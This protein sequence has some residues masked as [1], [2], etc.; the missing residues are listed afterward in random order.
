MRT[1]TSVATVMCSTPVMSS[2][3]GAWQTWP[4]KRDTLSDHGY[5]FPPE[6]I[7]YA[8]WLYHRAPQHAVGKMTEGPSKS[9]VR[10]R[11]QP[12]PRGGQYE[13]RSCAVGR[14]RA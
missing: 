14:R 5:R 13:W 4:M 2:L 7:S 10:S 3:V 9:A 8:V 1:A 6:I 12:T 11:L